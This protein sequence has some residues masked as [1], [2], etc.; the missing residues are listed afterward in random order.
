MGG[1]IGRRKCIASHFQ[2]NL[3]SEKLIGIT[4][5][6]QDCLQKQHLQ[7][8]KNILAKRKRRIEDEER[9]KAEGQL[10]LAASNRWP[11]WTHSELL[12]RLGA[13]LAQGDIT[14]A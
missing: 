7:V 2:P 14:R 1:S 5:C 10:G 9:A 8:L 12:L 6:H 3:L 4:L 13:I 11:H